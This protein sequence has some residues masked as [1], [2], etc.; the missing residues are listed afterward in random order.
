MLRLDP[1]ENLELDKQDSINHN[2]TLTSPSKIKIELPNKSY[3][4]SLQEINRKRRGLSS[5]FNDQDK[6][7]DNNN[8][9]ILDG[10]TNNRN[11]SSVSEISNQ[12][13][14]DDSVCKSTIV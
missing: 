1:I 2:S 7:F 14:V 8:I 3:V 10:V 9:T 5:V 12:K 4:D 6:E 13:Y 11:P